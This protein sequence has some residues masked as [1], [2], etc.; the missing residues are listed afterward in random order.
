MNLSARFLEHWRSE[1]S[2]P[3][4]RD[5]DDRWLSGSELDERSGAAALR[6]RGAG[7][8]P[9]DRVASAPPRAQLGD[10]VCCGPARWSVLVPINPAYTDSEVTRILTDARPA[11]ALL[12]GQLPPPLLLPRAQREGRA[13]RP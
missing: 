12:A 1:P 10:R 5:T 6:L 8:V 3:F 7:L 9:G 11:V 13:L 2:H 4:L